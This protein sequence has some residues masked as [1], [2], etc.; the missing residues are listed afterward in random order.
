MRTGKA[1]VFIYHIVM[2]AICFVFLFPFLYILIIALKKEEEILTYPPNLFFKPSLQN[3]LNV[4]ENYSYHI[5][6][7]NSIIVGL[8]AVAI[9]VGVAALGAYA[10]VRYNLRRTAL[11]ILAGMSVPYITCL[12]PL[13]ILFKNLRLLDT[14]VGLII[15]H[16]FIVAPQ[17]VWI[18]SGFV[19]AIPEQVEEAAIL[20]GCSRIQAFYKIIL[21]L[22]RPGL[23]AAGILTFALSWNDFKIAIILAG[24][25]TSTAPLGLY[26]FVGL[27][28]IDWGSMAA[29]IVIMII[30]AVVFAVVVQKQLIRGLAIGGF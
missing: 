2:S 11:L 24:P 18:L 27:E 1:K 5:N 21:P 30:P 10:I 9:G 13:Y 20:D 26:N 22:I 19:A 7:L 3:F 8:I 28:I 16:L 23:V 6:L 15:P 4:M 29:A 12:L 17:S 25:S 14:Y